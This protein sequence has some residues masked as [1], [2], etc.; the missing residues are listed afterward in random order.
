MMRK[1]AARAALPLLGA[2]I[3]GAPA[4]AETLEQ[5]YGLGATPPQ[6]EVWLK[7]GA[8]MSVRARLLDAQGGLAQT[9][10]P[11]EKL[12]LALEFRAAEGA[13]DR[14][15]DL[16]CAARFYDAEGTASAYQGAAVPCY[17]GRLADGAADFQPIDFTFVFVNDAEDPL[18][19]AAVVATV[20]DR[21]TGRGRELAPTYRLGR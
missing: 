14:A 18:G 16:T 11:G 20:R 5:A 8:D 12:H 1:G 3:L 2:L 7:L 17:H 4:G 6:P 10:R 19:T 21:A 13:A 9:A 15:L